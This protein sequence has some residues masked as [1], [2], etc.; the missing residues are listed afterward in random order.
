MYRRT[1][2]SSRG[3]TMME[4]ASECIVHFICDG[5]ATATMDKSAIP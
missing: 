3:M 4:P 5:L 2:L 1:M